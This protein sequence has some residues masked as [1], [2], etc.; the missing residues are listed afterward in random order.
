MAGRYLLEKGHRDIICLTGPLDVTV[1]EHRLRG[2]STELEKNGCSLPPENL[3]EGDFSFE[4][5]KK[6][7]RMLIKEGRPFTAL[8]AQNDPMALGAM[9]HIIESGYS[10]P[11][12]ISVMGM[13]DIDI[14]RQFIPGLT[15]IS[16]PFEE[17]C[18]LA[19]AYITENNRNLYKHTILP[20][21]LVERNSVRDIN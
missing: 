20:P 7:A 18:R 15:T 1:V 8:W 6:A 11:G 2:F 19:V 10:V 17:M 13:D 21:G 3:Y 9:H 5:G 16:Q 12:D 4:S 14:A